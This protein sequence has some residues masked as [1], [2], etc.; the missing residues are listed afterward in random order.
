MRTTPDP[1]R[2]SGMGG[3]YKTEPPLG[4]RGDISDCKPHDGPIK[5]PA[6]GLLPK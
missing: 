1:G 6:G 4:A 5:G 3:D 2:R